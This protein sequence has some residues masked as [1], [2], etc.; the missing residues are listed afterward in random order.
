MIAEEQLEQLYL[1]WLYDIGY[2]MVCGYDIA[3]GKIAANM[4]TI[5]KS[6]SMLVYLINWKSLTLKPLLPP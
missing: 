1:N 6:C 3:S 2:E 4:M 5:A